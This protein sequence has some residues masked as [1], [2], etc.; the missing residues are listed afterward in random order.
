MSSSLKSSGIDSNIYD[1][2][3]VD[4]AKDKLDIFISRNNKFITIANTKSEITKFI[5]QTL[6]F[7]DNPLVVCEST[8]GWERIML[9]CLSKHNIAS[10]TAHASKIYHYAK[11][12]GVLAKTDKLD[13]KIIALFAISEELKPSISVDSTQIE[14]K[15]LVMRKFQIKENLCT[16]LQRQ[17]KY[18]SSKVKLSIDKSISFYKKELAKLDK[19]IN[20]IFD[21]SDQYTQTNKQLKSMKGI[22]DVTSQT[23]IVLLPELGKINK[24]QIAAL[25]GVAPYNCD[26]GKKS[27]RRQIRGGR[28]EVR[29]TLYMASLSAIRYNPIMREYYNK[30]LDKGKLKKVAL[31]AVMRK[32]IIILN[33]II[34]NNTYF[35]ERTMPKT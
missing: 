1:Y 16:E 26:S 31:I 13:A 22:G 18:L 2:V 12:K 25:T 7:L 34:A 27:G 5:K 4:V 3:G 8:G 11:S 21:L 30:L 35:E 14:L 10:H 15:D 6:S 32:M 28:F 24:R 20:D 19:E 23:L 33:T 17:R 29:N 9:L